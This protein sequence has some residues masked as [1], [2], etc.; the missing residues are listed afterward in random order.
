[1]NRFIPAL[2]ILL[3]LQAA[4]IVH[5]Y[6]PRE[7]KEQHLF[8]ADEKD[9]AV[10]GMTVTDKE[11]KALTL[12]WQDNAWLVRQDD[13]AMPADGKKVNDR[14]RQLQNLAAD[15]LT[16]RTAGSHTRLEVAATLFQRQVELTF[17]SGAKKTLFLG[18]SPNFQTVHVRAGSDDNVYLVRGLSA[19][20]LSTEPRSWWQ[21]KYLVFAGDK[22]LS[23]SL[24]K[25]QETIFGKKEQEKWLV[26]TSSDGT[27]K[28][29]EP[30]KITALLDTM[31]LTVTDYL[32]KE[33]KQSWGL[34]HPVATLSLTVAGDKEGAE[35]TIS[36]AIGKESVRDDTT[37]AKKTAVLYVAK[38]TDAD[39]YV[40]L[41]QSA[42]EKLLRQ[43]AADLL[44]ATKP[45]PPKQAVQDQ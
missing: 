45:N 37:G 2:L 18:S 16:T 36:C 39:W 38:K 10:T 3:V 24:T 44:P 40:S 12:L 23:F 13:R 9:T 28:E 43:T 29:A 42:M 15:R 41:P 20:D 4:L 30:Q 17:G 35:T 7:K 19:W 11:G 26:S 34:D 32:G 21:E 22:A 5:M 14:L 33:E 31:Q 27:F 8:F 1:M 25:G 6:M